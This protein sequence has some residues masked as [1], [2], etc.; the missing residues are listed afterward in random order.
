[1][2]LSSRILSTLLVLLMAGTAFA[3]PVNVNTADAETLSA[4]LNGV[5]MSKAIAIAGVS[6]D[7]TE[8]A[9][10]AGEFDSRVNQAMDTSADLSSYVHRL[11]EGSGEGVRPEVADQLV[12]EIEQFLKEG[13]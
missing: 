1:M 5:G 9:V 10:E 7:A 8:L 3:G 12:D 11:E 2:T 13:D 6:I 4:E